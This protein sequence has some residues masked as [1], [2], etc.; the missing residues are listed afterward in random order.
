MRV[1]R[2]GSKMQGDLKFSK[3]HE[4]ASLKEKLV[5]MLQKQQLQID[6]LQDE[7]ASASSLSKICINL[8]YAILSKKNVFFIFQSANASAS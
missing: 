3:S 4:E 6:R 7:V 8:E 1:E 2:E 5:A